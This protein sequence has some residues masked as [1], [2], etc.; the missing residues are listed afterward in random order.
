[1]KRCDWAEGAEELTLYHDT[2]W[3]RPTHEDRIFFEFLVLEGA[4]AGLNWLTILK[5][6]EGYKKVFDN[7]DPEKLSLWNDKKIQKALS[8]TR[9]IRNRLKVHSVVENAKAFLEIQS[10]FGSFDSYIWDFVDGKPIVNRWKLLSQV[11]AE[12]P[13]SQK[14]SRELKKR[15]FRF[16]GP[17][18]V[19]S[20]LQATGLIDDHLRSC[21]LAK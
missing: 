3:G 6:R 11:P 19:Y 2:E 8:D 17:T 20:F 10:E 18:I 13:L 14:I 1:M 7:F 4:Q 15:D 21:Y 16:V 5:K 12:T 9:I